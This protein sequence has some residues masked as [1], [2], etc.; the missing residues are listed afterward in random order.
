MN[1]NIQYNFKYFN[2]Y[3]DYIF[4]FLL[5]YLIVN[6]GG[7]PVGLTFLLKFTLFITAIIYL[8]NILLLF[9][10]LAFMNIYFTYYKIIYNL[11]INFYN[12]YNV[13]NVL[14]SINILNRYYLLFITF[15]NA[16]IF[17]YLDIFL[18]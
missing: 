7:L 15:V 17:L 4:N 1:L 9:L 8:Q 2:F 14:K 12:K 16:D 6:I 5:L 3:T 18:L 13:Y 10:F 11:Y